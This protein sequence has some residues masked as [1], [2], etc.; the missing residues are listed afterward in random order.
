QHLRQLMRNAM[1]E[2]KQNKPPKSARELFR[3]LRDLMA[4]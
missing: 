1:R 3:Y 4:E 2:A